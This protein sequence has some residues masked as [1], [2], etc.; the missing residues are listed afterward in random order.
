MVTRRDERVAHDVC[1]ADAVSLGLLLV[2]L[3]HSAFLLSVEVSCC[4]SVSCRVIDVCAAIAFIP[5]SV[6]FEV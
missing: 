1:Q 6:S 4:Q 3:G 5:L 2:S